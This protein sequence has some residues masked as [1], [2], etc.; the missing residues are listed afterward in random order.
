MPHIF[1][2]YEEILNIDIGTIIIF[3]Y[4]ICFNSLRCEKSCSGNI[5]SEEYAYIQRTG[6][7]PINLEKDKKNEK[8]DKK[9]DEDKIRQDFLNRNIVNE[10][11]L[12]KNDSFDEED[13]WIEVKSKK[14]KKK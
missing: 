9:Y 8:N 4:V 2:V 6:E 11:D 10:K 13:E 7:K 12:D 5:F 1:M 3:T 14:G